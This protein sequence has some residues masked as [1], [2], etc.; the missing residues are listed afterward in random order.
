MQH[1]FC[2]RAAERE[3]VRLREGFIV[4]R[5]RRDGLR[6]LD[7][8]LRRHDGQHHHVQNQHRDRNAEHRRAVAGKPIFIFFSHGTTLHS[9][10]ILQ[11]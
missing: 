7:R 2:Q 5:I 6:Q 10:Q 11:I 3:C 8:G 9:S 1:T 4:Q